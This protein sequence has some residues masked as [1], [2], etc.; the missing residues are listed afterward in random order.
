MTIGNDLGLQGGWKRL[1][2]AMWGT[3]IGPCNLMKFV[4]KNRKINQS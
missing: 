2:K 1:G 4:E 3:F